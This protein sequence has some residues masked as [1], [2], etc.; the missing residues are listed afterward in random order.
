MSQL[1]K[2]AKTTEEKGLV[3]TVKS[4]KKLLINKGNKGFK[5]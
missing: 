3:Q 5:N 4:N 2:S 1:E